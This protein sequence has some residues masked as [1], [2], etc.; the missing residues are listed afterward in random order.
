[1]TELN[2]KKTIKKGRLIGAIIIIAIIIIAAVSYYFIKHSTVSIDNSSTVGD[3]A[4]IGSYNITVKKIKNTQTLGKT[5]LSKTN[6]DNNFFVAYV[7]VEN[8]SK[9]NIPALDLKKDAF[10]LYSNGKTYNVDDPT[11]MEISET[12]LTDYLDAFSKDG[13]LKPNVQYSI[14]IVFETEGPIKSGDLYINAD[15]KQIDYKIES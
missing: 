8:T 9:E 10:T 4:T 11:T 15:N 5:T 13:V 14:P 2:Q 7:S 1:M 3:S 12:N 6:T